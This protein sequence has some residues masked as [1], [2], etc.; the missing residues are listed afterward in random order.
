MFHHGLLGLD[1]GP[2]AGHAALPLLGRFLRRYQGRLAHEAAAMP[3]DGLAL[4]R[5]LSDLLPG[6]LGAIVPLLARAGDVGPRALTHG[7]AAYG[8]RPRSVGGAVPVVLAVALRCATHLDHFVAV[9][10]L[11]LAPKPAELA[12]DAAS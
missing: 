4:P 11:G 5:L 7:F 3:P 8:S 6:P 9:S 10:D 1:D 12:A 2:V